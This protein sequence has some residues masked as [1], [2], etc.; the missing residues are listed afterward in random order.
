LPCK[1]MR[2]NRLLLY[3]ER[4]V[5]FTHSIF[6]QV[7]TPILWSQYLDSGLFLTCHVT[8]A[9]DAILSIS[10]FFAISEFLAWVS[11]IVWACLWYLWIFIAFHFCA[12][13]A[14]DNFMLAV[15]KNHEVIVTSS[16]TAIFHFCSNISICMIRSTFFP[17]SFHMA[18][19]T[20]DYVYIWTAQQFIWMH[21]I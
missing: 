4:L 3:L 21:S 5:L 15:K 6:N 19:L 9:T 20:S 10:F 7:F 11:C 14:P 16:F 8:F 12:V 13:K 2:L 1:N 18:Y 17:A